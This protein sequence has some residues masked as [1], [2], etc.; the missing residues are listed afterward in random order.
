MHRKELI[1]IS[2]INTWTKVAVY[3]SVIIRESK[4][5][6]LKIIRE[7]KILEKVQSLAVSR[8]LKSLGLGRY[9]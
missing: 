2:K 3:N 7:K 9:I 8:Y 5:L 6:N 1:D 4:V